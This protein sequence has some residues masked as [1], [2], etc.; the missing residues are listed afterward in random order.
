MI[1]SRPQ[2]RS[3]R[4]AG[5]ARSD[6][7][8]C[9]GVHAVLW[10]F[11]CRIAALLAGLAGLLIAGRTCADSRDVPVAHSVAGQAGDIHQSVV[12]LGQ[13]FRVALTGVSYRGQVTRLVHE[14]SEGGRVSVWLA[15]RNLTLTVEQT[16]IVGGPGRADCGMLRL[17]LGHPREQWIGFDFKA[18]A[19]ARDHSLEFLGTRVRL[20]PDNWRVGTPQWVRTAGFGMNREGVIRG[21]Q[22]GLV[23]NQARL[24]SEL[25]RLAPDLLARSAPLME[26]LPADSAGVLA[27]ACAAL[28]RRGYLRGDAT[29]ALPAAAI[30]L[31]RGLGQ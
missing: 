20:A 13:A 12:H 2:P 17:M 26:H 15:V 16:A 14:R 3:G 28:Q 30:V 21:L 5:T 4:T 11:A 25:A 27:A 19:R 1:L 7:R 8:T 31:P 10:N 6:H 18:D 22:S 24:E 23:R 9:K 29:P